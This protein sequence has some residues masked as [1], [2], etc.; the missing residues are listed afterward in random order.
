MFESRKARLGCDVIDGYFLVAGGID[1]AMR[2]DNSTTSV[3][4]SAGVDGGQGCDKVR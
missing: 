2:V 3:D 1:L 4:G